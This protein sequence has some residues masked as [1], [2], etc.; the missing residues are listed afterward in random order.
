MKLVAKLCPVSTRYLP[1]FFAA[2]GPAAQQQQGQQQSKGTK[3]A[4]AL[5]KLPKMY[6]TPGQARQAHALKE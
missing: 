4:P 6:E 2:Q 3:S 5:Q 1:L